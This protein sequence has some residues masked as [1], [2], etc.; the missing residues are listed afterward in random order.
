M[1]PKV[2]FPSVLNLFC[3]LYLHPV[4]A[5]ALTVIFTMTQE[6][7]LSVMIQGCSPGGSTSN[8]VV[9]WMGGILDLR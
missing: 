8:V 5:W 4:L 9:Y 1:S 2:F 7:S 3:A 6:E